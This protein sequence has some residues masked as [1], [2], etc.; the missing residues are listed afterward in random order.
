MKCEECKYLLCN[1]SKII[2]VDGNISALDDSVP[3]IVQKTT[4]VTIA[5]DDDDWDE[6]DDDSEANSD[7]DYD[8]D[9]E[10]DATVDPVVLTPVPNQILSPTKPIQLEIH[11][12]EQVKYSPLPLCMVLNAR[13]IYNKCDN[14]KKL[15]YEVG[16]DISIISE[17]WERQ[18]QSIDELLSSDQF[19]TI[20]Y[21]R[22]KINNRQ[23]GG[24]LC[25]YL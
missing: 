16:P 4:N 2:Q 1:I 14:L 9:D 6:T 22:E 12:S 10:I 19:K 21:K 11:N 23:P 18:R 15:L 24:G 25:Y 7:I 17:T 3:D 5:S 8:T 20:S 13:S